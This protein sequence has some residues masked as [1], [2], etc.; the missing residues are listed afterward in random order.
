MTS[1]QR[2]SPDY[3]IWM[4]S[5]HGK[6]VDARDSQFT[7]E[8]L[9]EWKAQAQRDSGQRVL[10]GNPAQGLTARTYSPS[11]LSAGL[12][13]A[14]LADLD[15]F[16]RSDKWPSAAI[17]LTLKVEGLNNPVS[18]SALASA[19]TALDD[20]ILVAPPGTGKTTTLFQIADAL[21]AAQSAS[22]II[23]PLGVLGRVKP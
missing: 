11:E 15:V 8:L 5:L 23:V 16:R 7:V 1:E 9:R 3:G 22:P 10:Y 19:L 13:G 18:A 20:L 6:A 12:R 14:A 2:K 4:C 17:E 21:L